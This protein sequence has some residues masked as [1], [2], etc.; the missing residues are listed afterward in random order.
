MKSEGSMKNL[1]VSEEGDLQDSP[2]PPDE[3]KVIEG[4]KQIILQ[5]YQPAIDVTDAN[6]RMS[7]HEIFEG[8]C[9]IYH[10]E[11]F[12]SR[13]DLAAFLTEKGFKMWDA[14]DM[15]FEWLL[16]SI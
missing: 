11:M 5:T 3:L 16:R 13:N 14:G 4:L 2:I 9:R 6:K 10:N 1:S 7:T 8:C 12:F 15:R